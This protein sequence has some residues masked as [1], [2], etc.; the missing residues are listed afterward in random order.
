MH[1]PQDLMAIGKKLIDHCNKGTEREGVGLLYDE[2]AVSVEAAPMPGQDSAEAKG[3]EAILAKHD[4]WENNHEVHSSDVEGPFVHL[5]DRF[6]LIFT[7][8]VSDRNTGERTQMRDI[9]TYHVNQAGKII[10]E[11]FAYGF[12]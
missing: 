11:E 9:G 1:T 5:P 7:M 10:R 4:W 2:N 3:R 12:E 6:S 8:D